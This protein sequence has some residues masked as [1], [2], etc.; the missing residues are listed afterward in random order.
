[1]GQPIESIILDS[2]HSQTVYN[3]ELNDSIKLKSLE[4]H[5]LYNSAHQ[6]THTII[7]IIQCYHPLEIKFTGHSFIANGRAKY[8]N[9][10]IHIFQ[11]IKH[12][13]NIKTIE[14]HSNHHEFLTLLNHFSPS[15][16][17]LKLFYPDDEIIKNVLNSEDYATALYELLN[18]LTEYQKLESVDVEA[19]FLNDENFIS[20]LAEQIQVLPNLS[21]LRLKFINKNI[22]S[23]NLDIL[24]DSL[25]T[26]TNLKTLNLLILPTKNDV[27][28]ELLNNISKLKR[29]EDFE[30]ICILYSLFSNIIIFY[31]S[32]RRK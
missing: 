5:N 3:I 29:L 20:Q 11:N 1:M 14:M 6:F 13:K 21:Y 18:R 24:I 26:I 28:I 8:K 16:E 10:S 17:S 32:S 31:Y 25:L 27:I 22:K 4:V 7:K 9:A 19:F 30:F 2:I 15:L 23:L 12:L